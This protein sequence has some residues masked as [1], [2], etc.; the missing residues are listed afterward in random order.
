MRVATRAL[1]GIRGRDF[2]TP[3]DVKDL[4][5]PVYGHRILLRPE[6]EIEGHTVARVIETVLD[7][8]PVPR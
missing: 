2:V 7:R 4:A 8:V 5:R 1:A 6:S 3:D